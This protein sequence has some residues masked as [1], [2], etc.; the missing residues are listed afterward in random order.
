MSIKYTRKEFKKKRWPDD[1]VSKKKEEKSN[2]Q[3]RETATFCTKG[4]CTLKEQRRESSQA[5]SHL[6]K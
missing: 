2:L 3:Y 6:C 1:F 5:G 4:K